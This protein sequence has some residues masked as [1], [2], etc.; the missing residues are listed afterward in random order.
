MVLLKDPRR[1]RFYMSGVPL[2]EPA[3][4][5]LVQAQGEGQSELYNYYLC[6]T[7]VDCQNILKMTCWALR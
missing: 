1:W 3:K 2:Y 4:R 7:R 6:I 5:R